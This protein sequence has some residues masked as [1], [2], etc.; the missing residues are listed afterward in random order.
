ML[1]TGDDWKRNKYKLSNN[2]L[3]PIYIKLGN[4]YLIK[5]F[6]TPRNYISN[7]IM[8]Y[9]IVHLWKIGNFGIPLT[10]D[11]TLNKNHQSCQLTRK[12]NKIW[13]D[14][15]PLRSDCTCIWLDKNPLR[16]DCMFIWLDKNP[17]RSDSTCIWLDKNPLRSDCTCIWLDKNPLRSDCTCIWLDKNPL[18]SDWTSIWL[19]KKFIKVWFYMHYDLK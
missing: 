11:C 9:S 15:N 8:G 17:L 7:K 12:Q 3:V 18:R 5:D 16:S 6:F 13:L 10:T 14:K 4:A 2:H 1:F 19:D